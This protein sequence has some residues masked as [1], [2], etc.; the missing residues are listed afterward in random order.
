MPM[1][2]E[3]ALAYLRKHQPQSRWLPQSL[4]PATAKARMQQ[5][6]GSGADDGFVVMQ[7]AALAAGLNG[8]T[9]PPHLL[10]ARPIRRA[11]GGM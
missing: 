8:A 7:A 4:T 5:M 10:C 3:Q 11:P 1:N 9:L 6:V 2:R